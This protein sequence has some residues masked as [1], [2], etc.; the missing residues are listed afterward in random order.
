MIACIEQL[1]G[2]PADHFIIAIQQH[3]DL[4][5]LAV[6]V[7]GVEDVVGGEHPLRITDVRYIDIYT[8]INVGEVVLDCCDG[9]ISR[10]I[11]HEHYVIVRVVLH[12]DRH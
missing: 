9:V 10:E 12:Q 6:V 3:L 7:D 4:L 8:S 5:G 1:E 11:V 2:V